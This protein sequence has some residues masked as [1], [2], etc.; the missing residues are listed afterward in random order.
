MAKGKYAASGKGRMKF[1]AALLAVIL[2][3]G[4]VAGGTVAWLIASSGSVVNTF[5]YG[6]I[7]IKLEET[8]PETGNPEEEGNEYKMLPGIDIDKDPKVTVLKDSEDCW[9]FVRLE[10]SD[11]FDTFLTYAVAD[12]WTALKDADG[13]EVTGVYFR[14]VGAVTAEN[15]EAFAVL[16]DNTV[17]VKEDVTKEML[18]DLGTTYPTLT[19]TAYAVQYAGF[20]PKDAAGNPQDTDID[21]AATNTAAFGAWQKV[22]ESS[23]TNP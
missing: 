6:D 17:T 11:T 2:L 9:L 7:N 16:K 4:S 23:T 21:E 1:V 8:D 13:K 3:M 10:E 20:E 5:T 22:L 15:G 14:K 19:V 18:N 12:G